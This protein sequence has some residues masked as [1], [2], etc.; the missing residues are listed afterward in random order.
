MKES[1]IAKR[2]AEGLIKTLASENE[3]LTTKRELEEFLNVL[4]SIAEFRAGMETLL[5]SK[6]QKKEILNSIHQK[7]TFNKKTYQFLLTVL[8]E[9]RLIY[10][11]TIIQLL[12]KLWF[13]K[14]GIEKLHVF[15]AIP[16]SAELEKQLIRNLETAFNK[17]IVIEQEIAPSLIAGIKIQRG[18]VFYDFSIEGNLKKL[19]EALLADEFLTEVSAGG[20]H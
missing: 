13:E 19:K 20:E 4:N 10:L 7:I 2:Y 15:S 5:F 18:L 9:N 17:K 11:D 1:S 14:T 3:Y 16:L 12:E 8:E 6:S